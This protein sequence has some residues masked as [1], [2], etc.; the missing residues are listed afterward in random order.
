MPSEVPGRISVTELVGDHSFVSVASAIGGV[1]ANDVRD[2][3]TRTNSRLLTELGLK[4]PPL[5]LSDGTLRADDVVGLLRLSPRLELEIAPKYLGTD[6]P[7][8][9]DDFFFVAQLSRFGK[10]LPR[11]QLG[12]RVTGRKGLA[13]L[14]AGALVELYW[15]SFRRPLRTYRT[16]RVDDYDLVGEYDLEDLLFPTPDG[17]SQRVTSLT[18][19]NPYNSVAYEAARRLLVEVDDSEVRQR[20]VRMVEHLS[21]QTFIQGPRPARVP[22]R[23]QRWQP[24]YDLS[25]QIVD[26]F[27]IDLDGGHLSIAPGFVLRA[28][29]SWEDLVSHA[30]GHG[31]P[32]A[33]V[34]RQLGHVLGERDGEAFNTTPDLTVDFETKRVLVDAK[35]KGR[36]NTPHMAVSASDVYEGIAFLRAAECDTLLL[37]YPRR[38]IEDSPFQEVGTSEQFEHIQVDNL[39]IHA[40]EIEARGISTPGGYDG[41]TSNLGAR[42]R[43]ASLPSA[44]V[45]A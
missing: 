30:V 20:L 34:R 12:T 42:I 23:H 6:S 35:Y 24:L 21:P 31:L 16:N 1:S 40:F 25:A 14:V 37:L 18:R 19:A 29:K 27:G 15:D 22:S 5:Q 4:E 17:F 38:H 28:A 2:L 43:S 36:A 41:F 26:G 39:H 45:S 44:I 11:E 33:R 3:V 7:S 32:D 8:W 13:N 10:L 9:R